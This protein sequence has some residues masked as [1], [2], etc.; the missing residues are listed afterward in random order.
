MIWKT[1]YLLIF[2]GGL[3][4][5][6]NAML[7]GSER[8]KRRRSAK[9]SPL[10]NPPTVAALAAGFGAGGYLLYTRS[11]LGTLAVL[12]IAIII[13]AAAFVGM[14]FLMAKWAL[15]NPA[16]H[17]ESEDTNGQIARVSR[18]ITPDAPGEITYFAWDKKHVIPARSI[19]GSAI[20]ADTEVVI[21]TLEDGVARVELWS[22]VEQRL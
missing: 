17:D 14:T 8:W 16:S 20:P 7:H 4:L 1:T 22:V 18:D 11:Q 9:P 6:V 10:F 19:D 2:L 3:A 13:G 15:R 12:F 21:D 5:A